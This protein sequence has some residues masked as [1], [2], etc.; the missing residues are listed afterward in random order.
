MNYQSRAIFMLYVD[1][2]LYA[3]K[4]TVCYNIRVYYWHV[5][6]RVNT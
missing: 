3:R 1:V 2:L 4:T 6:V 5:L